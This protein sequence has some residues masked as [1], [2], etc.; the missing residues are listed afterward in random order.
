MEACLSRTITPDMPIEEKSGYAWQALACGENWRSKGDQRAFKAFERA[1]ELGKDLKHWTL[2]SESHKGLVVS[3][4]PLG[5]AVGRPL[6]SD[7][8]LKYW[9]AALAAGRR[10]HDIYLE[11]L[12]LKNLGIMNMFYNRD[13]KLLEESYDA[14]VSLMKTC[15]MK[16][17]VGEK[18]LAVCATNTH[19]ALSTLA[20]SMKAS[21]KT[22][23]SQVECTLREALLYADMAPDEP[24]HWPYRHPVLMQLANTCELSNFAME[25]QGQDWR[26]KA[27]IYRQ[28]AAHLFKRMGN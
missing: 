2:Q 10:H 6:N 24:S 17:P 5:S 18:S 1:L 7:F 16:G 12:T 14:W 11:A 22:P 28:H 27:A 21:K 19:M 15:R 9:N 25:P 13:N 8:N 20:Q 4:I 26:E 3:C 23:T